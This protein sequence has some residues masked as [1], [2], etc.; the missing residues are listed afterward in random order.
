[1][2]EPI[3]ITLIGEAD[4][5]WLPSRSVMA[6]REK[7]EKKKEFQESLRLNSDR[8]WKLLDALCRKEE[9]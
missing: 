4:K 6:K 7:G 8:F 1:M 5:E 3:D 9:D 2:Y